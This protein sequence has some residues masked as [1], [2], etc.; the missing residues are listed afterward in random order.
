MNQLDL[1][2]RISELR[3]NKNMTQ[4]ET[5]GR[6]GV[7]P[8]ASVQELVKILSDKIGTKDSLEMVLINR[9]L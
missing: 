7:T 8:Q 6:L 2:S 4:G 9:Q 5:A 1:G 3:Q